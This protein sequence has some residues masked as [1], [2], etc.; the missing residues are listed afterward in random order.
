MSA[1][2][3]EAS[4]GFDQHFGLARATGDRG[5]KQGWS[6]PGWEPANLH[7]V[8][9]VDH[10]AIAILQTSPTASYATMRST[11]TLTATLLAGDARCDSP[12]RPSGGYEAV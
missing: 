7:S 8:G 4:D 5:A 12:V 11:S 1:D 10:F 6:D 2:T 9:W 3:P